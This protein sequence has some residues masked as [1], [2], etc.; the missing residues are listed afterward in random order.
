MVSDAKELRVAT[1]HMQH[2]ARKVAQENE[3]LRTLL[4]RQ[5]VLKAK[6]DAFRRMCEQTGN[7][8]AKPEA[9][10]TLMSEELDA[11]NVRKQ[12]VGADL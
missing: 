9:K 2:A 7:V 10:P 8:S 1:Q 5:R 6:V 11:G 12:E 3:R 4:T